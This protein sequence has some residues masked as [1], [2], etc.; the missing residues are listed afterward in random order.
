MKSWRNLNLCGHLLRFLQ[1]AVAP[2]RFDFAPHN[3]NLNQ[4]L[5]EIQSSEARDGRN[6]AI[7]FTVT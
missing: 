7:R 2:L 4:V 5:V 3:S 6:V 1:R